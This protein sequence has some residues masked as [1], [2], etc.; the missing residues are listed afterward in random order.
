MIS[1]KNEWV[2]QVILL[3][4]EVVV[5]LRL[6]TYEKEKTR[7]GTVPLWSS[8]GSVEILY[9]GCYCFSLQSGLKN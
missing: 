5:I 9:G 2:Y 3:G 8:G 7:D 6:V 4:A 1:P